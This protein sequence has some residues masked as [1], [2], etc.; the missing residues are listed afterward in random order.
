[1]HT[2]DDLGVHPLVQAR[3]SRNLTQLKVADEVGIGLNTYKRAERGEPLSLETCR[4]ITAFF[5]M[6]AEDLDL[7][8]EGPSVKNGTLSSK[9]IEVPTIVRRSLPE[10]SLAPR[11]LSEQELGDWLVRGASQLTPLIEAGWSIESLLES[12]KIV[13]RGV[14][15]MPNITRRRLLELAAAFVV[16]DVPIISGEHTSAEERINLCA[17]LGQN[18]AAGWNLFHSAGN[19][20]VYAVGQA[21]LHLVQANHAILPSQTR[22]IFYT[23]VFNLM[24][25]ALHFQEHYKEALDIHVNA[26]IAALSTGDP[27]NVAQSLICQAD[28]YQA[29]AQHAKA[30]EVIEEAINVLG[31]STIEAHVRSKAHALACW[32]DN[33]MATG[34][35][36][37]AEK[38]L[39]A[40]AAYLDHISP[41]EEFDR[42]SWL[43]LAGKN[44]LM[45]GEYTEAI[46]HFEAA[47]AQPAK[48]LRSA[49]ILIPLAMA[50]ARV[51][52]RDA[53][54]LVARKLVPV[55]ATVDAQML[56][57]HFAEY[58]RQDLLEAF[59]QDRKVL[60][61]VR[62]TQHQ[63]PQFSNL[64]N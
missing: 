2:S 64:L 60:T 26:H 6:S 14:Q 35:H 1:M 38:K 33:A 27:W 57:V 9:A 4:R 56:N 52:E 30:I 19:A 36:P 23:S 37:T 43:Q 46:R 12:F 40:S 3:R 21:H 44:A 49:G 47:L 18:I 29:L 53:S 39:E 11:S 55:I 15:S 24:G 20:Q 62:D 16:S 42:A 31:N 45:T 63:L 50:Y 5:G 51:R 28:S 7:V 59:P 13:L 25:R 17:A 22:S 34:D 8:K 61:F 54:L 48:L 41:E 32:A 58:I 10:L